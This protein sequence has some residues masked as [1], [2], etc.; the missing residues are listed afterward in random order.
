[1]CPELVVECNQQLPC[2]SWT[3]WLHVALDMDCWRS[4]DRLS[5]LG[6]VWWLGKHTER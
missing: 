6:E 5:C 3:Q 4:G 2:V 1:M